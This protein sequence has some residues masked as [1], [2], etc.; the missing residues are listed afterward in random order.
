[1][2]QP[3]LGPLRLEHCNV[4]VEITDLKYRLFSKHM[5]Q[6]TQQQGS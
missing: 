3:Y 5:F 1:M 2:R 6:R 4:I